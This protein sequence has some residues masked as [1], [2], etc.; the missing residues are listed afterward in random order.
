MTLP[1][2]AEMLAVAN[3]RK[4]W[5]AL[6]GE[7]LAKDGFLIEQWGEEADVYGCFEHV[8]KATFLE[9]YRWLCDELYGDPELS[10]AVTV[11]VVRRAHVLVET[12]EY[13]DEM[14]RWAVPVEGDRNPMGSIRTRPVRAEDAGAGAVTR[15]DV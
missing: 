4:R 3:E 7:R 12:D 15:L 2:Y 13:G 1:T 5:D 14:Y 8:D 9:Q 11:E 6:G 10:E